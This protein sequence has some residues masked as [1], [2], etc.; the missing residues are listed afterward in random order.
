VHAQ[1]FLVAEDAGFVGHDTG[2]VQGRLAIEEENV[3]VLEVAVNDLDVQV[4]V[5]GGLG[6][7]ELFGDGQA[8][9]VVFAF[10]AEGVAVAVFDYAGAGVH[11][12]T[13]KD[14]LFHFLMFC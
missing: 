10:E 12:W 8:T 9:L 5:D 7:E 6:R 4:A 13:V 14:Q 11:V 2:P 3:A 1:G